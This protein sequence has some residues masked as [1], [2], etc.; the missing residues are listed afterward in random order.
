[1]SA[2]LDA[3]YQLVHAY[4]GGA[5]SLAPRIGKNATTLR[6]E[7]NRTGAAKLGLGDAVAMSVMAQDMRVLN[8]FAAECGCMVLQMPALLDGDATAMQRVATLAR[9]FGEVVGSVT[10]A[11]ADGKVSANE[12]HHVQEEWSQLVAAGQALLAHLQARHEAG[13]PKG[14]DA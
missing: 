12:L 8:A 7:V 11:A 5:E 4:P 9:E 10:E 1:M 14:G 3:A 2:V 13:I 6:H